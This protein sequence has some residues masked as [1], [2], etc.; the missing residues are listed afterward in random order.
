MGNLTNLLME[1]SG[2]FQYFLISQKMWHHSEICHNSILI[3]QD[4][5]I[6]CDT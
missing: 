6:V 1:L 2:E 5:L 3:M 4:K